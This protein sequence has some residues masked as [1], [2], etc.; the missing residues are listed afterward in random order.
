MLLFAL[1]PKETKLRF[2][3]ADQIQKR[4]SV[5]HPISQM[6]FI[7]II[8]TLYFISLKWVFRFYKKLSGIVSIVTLKK[9]IWCEQFRKSFQ[10]FTSFKISQPRFLIFLEK[11]GVNEKLCMSTLNSMENSPQTAILPSPWRFSA[12]KLPTLSGFP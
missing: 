3:A 5:F 10:F 11:T 1:L 8:N 7:H 6:C 9:I 12:L 2:Q 4:L